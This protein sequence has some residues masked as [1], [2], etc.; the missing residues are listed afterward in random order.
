MTRHF[1]AIIVG[2]GISGETCAHRLRVGGMRV[3]LV[4]AE[5]IGGECAYWA[6]IPQCLCW[7]QRTLAGEQGRSPESRR[8]PLLRPGV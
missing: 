3:A 7:D 2:A 5:H 4:E 8:P 1:D 6:S